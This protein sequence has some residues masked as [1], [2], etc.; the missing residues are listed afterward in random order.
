MKKLLFSLAFILVSFLFY[1]KVSAATSPVV[2]TPTPKEQKIEYNLPYPGILPDHPLYFLKQIRDKIMDFLIV[3]PVRKAEFYI[4]QADKR[5]SMGITLAN[6]KKNVL[7]EVTVS[8]GEKYMSQAVE[9]LAKMK[10][11]GTTIPGNLLSQITQSIAKH[12]EVLEGM[13]ANETGA[14]KAGL[15]GSLELVK[16]LQ[17]DIDRLK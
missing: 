9:T 11:A 1:S 2:V 4:L 6:D 8:K 10:A 14:T 5:L 13:I 17:G 3:D 12:M 16:K 7:S 15:T